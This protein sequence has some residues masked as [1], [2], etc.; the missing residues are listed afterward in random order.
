[1]GTQLV[2]IDHI[3]DISIMK[4]LKTREEDKD[5]FMK[6]EPPDGETRC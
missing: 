5:H 4:E 1:M 6:E 2:N 3:K